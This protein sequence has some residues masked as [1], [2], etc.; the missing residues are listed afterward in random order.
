MSSI[1]R[2]RLRAPEADGA[3]LIDPPLVELPALVEKNR[4]CV[5]RFQES[6]GFSTEMCQRARRSAI[7]IPK[8]SVETD[9][10][11]D[12][13]RP[14][15]ATGHQPELFHPGVWFKNFLAEQVA[16]QTNAWALNLVIDNDLFHAPGI[17]V[18]TKG[19]AGP[20]VAEVLFDEPRAA[21]T[22]E[23]RNLVSPER[24][25]SFPRAVREAF[26]SSMTS[27]SYREGVLLDQ[28]WPHV[29]ASFEEQDRDFRAFH[30]GLV[31]DF[32]APPIDKYRPFGL[33][34]DC[35]TS[36]RRKIEADSGIVLRDCPMSEIAFQSPFH[37]FLRL[38]F[39][40][41]REFH[42]I[43]NRALQE[44]RLIH[45][46][47][48]LTHPVPKLVSDG[49]WLEMPL[50][51]STF[52]NSQRRP[53]FVREANECLEISDRQDTTLALPKH[54]AAD[55]RPILVR[56]NVI[57]RPR[58]LTTTMYAR[59]VLSDL[60]IHGIGGAKYDELTDLIIRR[61]FGIEPPAYVTATATFRLP[62]E[63]PSVSLDDVRA[64]AERI[65]ELRYRP[66]AFVRD[67]RVKRGADL[68]NKLSAL[69]AEKREYLDKHD[70]R[71]CSPDVFGKL[72]AMNRA[73][74]DL[75]RPVEEEL[76]A[77]HAE[78]IELAR[79]SRLLGSREFSFVLFPAEKLPARLL[80]LS[81]G[82]A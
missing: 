40:R 53:L 37:E 9:T 75:L 26:A 63:R 61:F 2:R 41:F 69:A 16:R 59:L 48:S 54:N 49:E 23:H 24:L 76:R 80:E 36:A 21:T 32:A 70:L 44:Y 34:R 65:R 35:F 81:G 55:Y 56:A 3:A 27:A 22:W 73:M 51:I 67:E 33:L 30:Q 4:E 11:L 43:H 47:R 68:P 18:P 50:W 6:S 1:T 66:E 7:D 45:G 29:V 64:S 14:V 74:Q 58:A 78:L 82:M 77:R 79:Q 10:T 62:I 25:R 72:D 60:F 15:V 28:F 17:R 71:R 5:R 57:I 42:D 52:E 20:Q 46:I 38:L 31:K 19:A 12:L 8:I 39:V 13:S